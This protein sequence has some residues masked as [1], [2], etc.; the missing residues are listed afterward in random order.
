MQ[1]ILHQFRKLFT[2]N[3]SNKQKIFIYFW[4]C[5]RTLNKIQLLLCT[6]E[7]QRIF[8]LTDCVGNQS[9]VSV[10]IIHTQKK[11]I[12]HP[13]TLYSAV[14]KNIQSCN[15]QAESVDLL[16][17]GRNIYKSRAAKTVRLSLN[18]SRSGFL[19]LLQTQPRWIQTWTIW[20]I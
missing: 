10:F 13:T 3:Y 20:N 8:R 18:N 6:Y 1:K 15:K 7:L 17:Q 4:K 16:H 2:I 12:F 9:W 11:F 19:G 5:L 14:L